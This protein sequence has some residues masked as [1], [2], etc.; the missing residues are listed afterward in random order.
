VGRAWSEGIRHRRC[1]AALVHHRSETAGRLDGAT[2]LPM[3]WRRLPGNLGRGPPSRRTCYE[4]RP[5]WRSPD[6]RTYGRSIANAI[7]PATRGAGGRSPNHAGWISPQPWS[8]YCQPVCNELL[9]ASLQ[10][11][12]LK[13]SSYCQAPCNEP[14]VSLPRAVQRNSCDAER[15]PTCVRHRPPRCC[16]SPCRR[17]ARSPPATPPRAERSSRPLRVDLPFSAAR[18]GCPG[19]T[20]DRARFSNS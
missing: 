17:S 15:R 3:R 20:K 6:P 5:R 13:Q 9:P 18:P 14:L 2:R 11:A 4:Q 10:R 1:R 8:A 19:P 7:R 12:R 16:R